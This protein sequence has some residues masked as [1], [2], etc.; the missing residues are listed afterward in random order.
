MGARGLVRSGNGN[1]NG[2]RNTCNTDS[3]TRTF[4]CRS[5]CK[6]FS[7]FARTITCNITRHFT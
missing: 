2:A 1:G 7:S 6:W 5:T 3:N 4:A